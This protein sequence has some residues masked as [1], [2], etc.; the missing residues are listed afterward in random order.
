MP[1]TVTSIQPLTVGS[2]Y[3]N[4]VGKKRNKGNKEGKE[5]PKD[6]FFFADDII[7]ILM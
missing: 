3:C 5:E 6:S 1:V 4:R 7:F 2:S